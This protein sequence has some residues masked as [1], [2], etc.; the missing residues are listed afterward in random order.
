MS[1]HTNKIVQIKHGVIYKKGNPDQCNT[2]FEVESPPDGS[3]SL[4]PGSRRAVLARLL[5]LE[6]EDHN[7]VD[8]EIYRNF[9]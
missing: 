4:A 3:D 7:G 1:Q 8:L 9:K 6:I 5:L 2:P